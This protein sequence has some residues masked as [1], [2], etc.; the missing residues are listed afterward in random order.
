MADE[1]MEGEAALPPRLMYSVPDEL[2]QAQETNEV[3]KFEREIP[4]FHASPPSAP[5][6]DGDELR[7]NALHLE[8]APITQLSTS[9]LMAYVAQFGT[10]ACGIEWINDLRCVIVFESYEDTL[11]GL[12]RLCVDDDMNKFPA[13][14]EAKEDS[15]RLLTPRLA[16]AF[17]RN[18]YNTIERHALNEFPEAVAKLEEA[19]KRLESSSD[20]VPEIYRDMELEDLEKKIFTRDQE[21]VRQ[22]RQ[23]LWVRFALCAHDTKAPR[24]ASRSNWYRQHG[25]GAGKEVVTRLL[26]VGDV[27]QKKPKRELLSGSDEP[28]PSLLERLEAGRSDRWD[29]TIA[30]SRDRSASPDEQEL[31]IRGR[32]AARARRSRMAAWDDDTDVSGYDA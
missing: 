15:E 22:L 3:S 26:D 31:R 21:R 16:Y 5:S 25:R 12:R 11:Q 2:T 8:G 24:S 14:E 19:R 29:D 10:H 7:L 18:L 9:R 20:P 30:S 1:P 17:P 6:L 28:Q 13:I 4:E 32:G 23:S 27:T